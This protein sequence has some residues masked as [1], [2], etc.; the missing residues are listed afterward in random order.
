VASFQP[1]TPRKR[2]LSDASLSVFHQIREDLVPL[3]RAE[4]HREAAI[5]NSAKHAQPHWHFSQT[6]ER[7][8]NIVL[9]SIR[10]SGEAVDFTP[11]RKSEL[12][13]NLADCGRFHFAMTTLWGKNDHPPAKRVFDTDGFLSWFGGLTV[14]IAGQ[15]EHLIKHLPSNEIQEFFRQN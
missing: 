2:A 12:F 7:I 8:E 9:D 5:D 11:T 4:W 10:P 13:S 15:V 14:Y 6:P 3:F 1:I